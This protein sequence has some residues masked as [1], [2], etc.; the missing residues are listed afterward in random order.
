MPSRLWGKRAVTVAVAPL[1]RR[2]V[3]GAAAVVARPTRRAD[4]SIWRSRGR[5][6]PCAVAPRH[7]CS[8]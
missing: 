5:F 2:V 7:R 3:F 1:G 6:P 8:C 4:S